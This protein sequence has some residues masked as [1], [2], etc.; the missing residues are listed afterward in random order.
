M[1]GPHKIA[2]VLYGSSCATHGKGAR[3]TPASF[4]GRIEPSRAII[5][6]VNKVSTVNPTVFVSN[7]SLA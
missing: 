3:N 4:G 6:W 2:F 7:P 1:L 5:R